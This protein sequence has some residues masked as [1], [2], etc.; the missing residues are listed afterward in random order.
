MS[1]CLN[2]GRHFSRIKPESI[3]LERGERSCHLCQP[4]CCMNLFEE[5]PWPV[6]HDWVLVF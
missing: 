5:S 3:N 2:A 6:N 4:Q 1:W